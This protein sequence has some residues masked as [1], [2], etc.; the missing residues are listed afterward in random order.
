[1][2]HVKIFFYLILLLALISCK[3]ES[4]SE[5]EQIVSGEDIVISETAKPIDDE[6]RNNLGSFDSTFVFSIPSSLVV[7]KNLKVNDVLIDKPGSGAPYG[8]LR[9]I[10]SI[11]SDGTQST[12]ATSQATLKDVIK[13]GKINVENVQLGKQNLVSIKLIDGAKIAENPSL[14]KSDMIGIN[15]DYEKTIYSSGNDKID[16]SGSFAFNFGLNFRLDIGLTGVEYFKTSV[17]VNQSVSM[18][19]KSRL[20]KDLANIKIPFAKAYFTPITIM[21]GIIPIVLVPEVTL[22]LGADGKISAETETWCNESFDGEYGI[23]YD[24]DK[25]WDVINSDN[26]TLDKEFPQIAGTGKFSAFVGPQTSLKLYGVAGPYLTFNTYAELESNL[27]NAKLEYEFVIGFKSDAGVQVELFGWELL[28][29][30]REVFSKELFRFNS[31]TGETSDNFRIT[32]PANDQELVKGDFVKVTTFYSG[33]K[34]NSVKFFI[35]NTE[36]FSTSAEPFEYNLET[37]NLSDGEHQIKAVAQYSNKTIESIVKIKLAKPGWTKIDLG[38]LI[39]DSDIIYKIYFVNDNLGFAVGGGLNNSLILKTNDGGN[40]WTKVLS[41]TSYDD[42]QITDIVYVSSSELYA[43]R[44][45]NLFL[46]TN[47]GNSWDIFIPEGEI[48]SRIGGTKLALTSEGLILTGYSSFYLKASV[49]Q[50]AIW[51]ETYASGED[52]SILTEYIGSA[53]AVKYLSNK[54]IVVL[55][56]KDINY[57]DR[58]PDQ[59]LI[60]YD[61]GYTWKNKSLNIPLEWDATDM[62]FPD[63]NNG[64]IVG[65]AENDRG[66]ILRTTDGGESW[67]TLVNPNDEQLFSLFA[68]DFVDYQNG[69]CGGTIL[70]LNQNGLSWH[71]GILSSNNSGNNWANTSLSGYNSNGE[72]RTMFFLSKTKGWAA[73]SHKVLY[74]YDTN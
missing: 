40:T 50:G 73:G 5:P 17:E 35:D 64:W 11:S 26:F 57:I 52:G 55:D 70:D 68:V 14:N 37:Q 65:K 2:K 53:R 45:D 3:K 30:H 44:I 66:F 6:L 12:V 15:W 69:F 19:F 41:K 47:N 74:K 62:D 25:G 42:T 8:F 29:T 56:G 22:Y 33:T 21:A 24:D 39:T 59:L 67:Q 34:P 27:Q 46:S 16:I 13:Q 72:I 63:E 4:P 43:V 61:G 51:T 23:K 58:T 48:N 32:Y 54:K 20:T 1:M 10:I 28:N 36:K 49:Q 7:S 60:S 9:K 38:G 31:K 18:R 71:Q